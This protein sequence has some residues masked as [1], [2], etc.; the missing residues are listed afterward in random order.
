[1][2]TINSSQY[3]G[4]I[5]A[6]VQNPVTAHYKTLDMIVQLFEGADIDMDP[7][8]PFI[9]ALDC[10]AVN[11]A[12]VIEEHATSMRQ[13][14]PAA[15]TDPEDL[16]RHMSDKDYV[17][18]FALPASANFIVAIDM[19]DLDGLLVEDPITKI[20][21]VIIPRNTYFQ[22]AGYK[23]SLEYPISIRKY[24]NSGYTVLQVGGQTSPLTP[25]ATNNI[26]YDVI[27]ANNGIKYLRFEVPTKQFFITSQTTTVTYVSGRY[28][29]FEFEDEFVLARA[30]IQNPLTKIWRELGVT[31]N[32]QTFDSDN[33]T[34]AVR[35][36]K[37]TIRF[38][39]PHVFI[40]HTDANKAIRGKVRFD[41]YTTR[42]AITV[43]LKS[44]PLQNFTAV[45]HAIDDADWGKESTALKEIRNIAVRSDDLVSG[46]RSAL[47]FSELKDRVMRNSLG[48]QNLPITS[49]QTDTQ[50]VDLGYE[51]HT[52]IDT[53]TDRV[54]HGCKP[55]PMP[56]NPTL[57]TAASVGIQ[58][59]STRVDE[60]VHCPGVYQR[61]S[62]TT[63]TSGALYRNVGGVLSL[64]GLV[65]RN[66]LSACDPPARAKLVNERS[67]FY[68]PFYYVLD[69]SNITF[70][71][72]TYHLD[73][74]Q[75]VSKA[76]EME[77][78]SSVYQASFTAQHGVQ[79]YDENGQHGYKIQI[80]T[81]SN[82]AFKELYSTN[83][84]V[85]EDFTTIQ[86]RDRQNV[87]VQ[88]SFLPKNKS[89]RVYL[90]AT[91]V[92]VDIMTLE[93]TY[94]FR[95]TTDFIV[96]QD[97]F[98]EWT[99][100][101]TGTTGDPCRTELRTAFDITV[102]VKAA[103]TGRY[104]RTQMDSVAK[105]DKF[106]ESQAIVWEKLDIRFGVPTKSLWCQSRSNVAAVSY[107]TYPQDIEL[108]YEDD[109]YQ[110]DSETGR[111]MTF[112]SSG[113]LNKTILHRRGEVVKV[114]GEIQYRHR[115]GDVVLDPQGN[116]IPTQD[117][118]N[119][120]M[121][122][123][124]MLMVEG[125]YFFATE[126]ITTA[127]RHYLRDIM[128]KWIVDELPVFQ[129]QMLEKTGIYF[130]PK[131]TSGP[132]TIITPFNTQAVIDSAQ[133]ITVVLHVPPTVYANDALRQTLARQAVKI[134]D[135]EFKKQLVSVSEIERT[136]K[137][138]YG[139]DVVN[140]ELGGVTGQTNY[141]V[142]TVLDATRR[143]GIRKRLVAYPDGTLV[144]EEDVTVRFTSHGFNR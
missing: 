77:N 124:D 109:V 97:D 56:T 32:Q 48:R 134:I 40:H 88:L 98:I 6:Y 137:A 105:M 51:I 67:Y 73:A 71:V 79:V 49:A 90:E 120:L 128:V 122:Y 17:G 44:Q 19:L 37:Q 110:M 18:R 138:T 46:G 143:L 80:T 106:A 113:R 118:K 116:P 57:L 11:T 142:L 24:P 34:V 72:R 104:S 85:G 22:V 133:S 141:P 43:D 66:E 75:I 131:C 39:I 78:T 111:L 99:G 127:Y 52:H 33:P 20:R 119:Q 69:A 100:L 89:E 76:F 84:L 135:S 132:L 28:H 86:N 2:S 45:W 115:K 87:S 61:G 14:H 112:D 68:S 42:G 59:L 8:N 35:V 38:E 144:V 103:L 125:A 5:K 121:R 7:S 1:M 95:L 91:L 114:G 129:S 93:R 4:A 63:L 94:E 107:R 9:F 126:A 117:Y 140:I 58:T 36:I 26:E 70:E 74:P 54:F 81:K 10:T 130:F 27:T 25:L 15:A 16:Y 82:A 83:L 53:V 23:F 41:V 136:M 55:A 31:H 60:A 102:V 64:V 65:E 47:M 92:H 139:E 62:I 21:Q 123:V 13:L 96:D 50:L 101:P 30:F 12:I 3:Y 29:A 108:R